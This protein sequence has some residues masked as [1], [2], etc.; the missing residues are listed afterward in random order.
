ME[1]PIESQVCTKAGSQHS[2]LKKKKK[3]ND[4]SPSIRIAWRLQ[5][6]LGKDKGRCAGHLDCLSLL[7]DF[8]KEHPVPIELP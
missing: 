2:A 3:E 7:N 1:S 5:R 8:L 4:P 6:K